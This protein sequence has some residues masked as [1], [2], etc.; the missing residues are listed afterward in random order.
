MAIIGFRQD[1]GA[2]PGAGY[3]K[4]SDGKEKF[5]YAPEIAARFAG[6]SPMPGM[7]PPGPQMPGAPD[8]R[9]AFGD[10]QMM[11]GGPPPSRLDAGGGLGAGAPPPIAA[12]APPPVQRSVP[13]APPLPPPQAPAPPPVGPPNA[14]LPMQQE[15]VGDILRTVA[16]APTGPR[17]PAGFV[18]KSQSVTVESG[19]PYSEEQANDRALAEANLQQAHLASTQEFAD[20]QLA[21]AAAAAIQRD[22]L[23]TEAQAAAAKQQAKEQAY[24]QQRAKVQGLM[25]ATSSQQIDPGRWFKG[26]VFG[27]VM[28][29]IGQ[30]MQNHA[31][32]S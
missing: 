14:A 13:V 27:G 8:M 23:Q 32:I 31:A 4:G 7:L 21:S 6:A 20:N 22:R 19:A 10:A 28:A 11:P 3:F 2:P 1:P 26:N 30:A 25:D 18:P 12:P 9:L 15:G 5:A 16:N 24:Q 17:K 29:V